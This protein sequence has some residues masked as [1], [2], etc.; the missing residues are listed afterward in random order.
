MEDGD[1][2]EVVTVVAKDDVVIGKFAVG[3]LPGIPEVDVEDIAFLVVGR[4]EVAA[5]RVAQSGDEGEVVVEVV[6]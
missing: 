6:W 5:W 1:A 3:G 4:A 2:D